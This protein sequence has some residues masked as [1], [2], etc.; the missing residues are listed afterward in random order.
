MIPLHFKDLKTSANPITVKG[1]IIPELA[2][3]RGISSS[4]SK[5]FRGV[6]T[7]Y[8]HQAPIVDVKHDREK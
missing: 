1:L 4:I 3:D 8:W 6:E 2:V 7:A 5:V